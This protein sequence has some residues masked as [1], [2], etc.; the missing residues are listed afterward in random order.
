M[1]DPDRQIWDS[2][3]SHLRSHHSGICR[4]WFAELEPAGI[5]A[6]ALHVRAQR[7][8]Q[9]IPFLEAA[10]ALNCGAATPFFLDLRFE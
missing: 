4:A 9:A 3:L 1:T 2:I 7:E 6:G 5:A 8:D 10:I